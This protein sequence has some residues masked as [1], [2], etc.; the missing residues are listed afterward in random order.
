MQI[1]LNEIDL[2]QSSYSNSVICVR[3]STSRG[4]TEGK[5]RVTI[6]QAEPSPA[7]VHLSSRAGLRQGLLEVSKRQVEE[8]S[9]RSIGELPHSRAAG[10]GPKAELKK[11]LQLWWDWLIQEECQRCCWSWVHFRYSQGPFRRQKQDCL[12]LEC[13]SDKGQDG[14]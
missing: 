6:A 12:N 2:G 13:R 4:V 8:P 7:L 5:W 10:D 1:G 3:H 11:G 14:D 9:C